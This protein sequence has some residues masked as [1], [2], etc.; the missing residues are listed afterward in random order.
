MYTVD[1][2]ARLRRGFVEVEK[3]RHPT[4]IEAVLRAQGYDGEGRPCCK[5]EES[6]KMVGSGSIETWEVSATLGIQDNKVEILV[7]EAQPGETTPIEDAP[8][9]TLRELKPRRMPP[10]TKTVQIHER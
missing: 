7:G 1:S 5:I 10:K 9:A 4:K 6:I 8:M 3:P 2:Q